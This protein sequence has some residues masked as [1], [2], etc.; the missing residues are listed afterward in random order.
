MRIE[1]NVSLSR[2]TTLKIGGGCRKLY[3]PANETELKEVLNEAPGAP[4]I[5]G[6]SNLLVDDRHT[7]PAAI[8]M[9]EFNDYIVYNNETV[10]VGAGVRLQKF[11]KDINEHGYVGIEYLY[12]VPGLIGGAVCMNAGRG[13]KYNQCISDYIVS[14]RVSWGSETKTLLKNDCDF[15]YRHSVFQERPMIILSAEFRFP[16]VSVEES[17]QRREDRISLTKK[18]QDNRYP[19]AGTTFCSADPRIM[20]L[21]MKI[22]GHKASR[23]HFSDTHPNWLQNRGN[24]TFDEAVTLLN[25]VEFAHRILHKECKQEIKII[26]QEVAFHEIK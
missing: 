25:R 1:K 21:F 4:I 19:N 23:C 17:K 15:S 7:F 6:G 18:T 26:S 22:S 2:Y 13:R 14:V 3:F 8:C 24:G 20:K 12:S 9:R 16:E 10:I 5:G 11:I